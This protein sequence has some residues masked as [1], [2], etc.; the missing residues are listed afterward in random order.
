MPYKQ[1]SPEQVQI[2]LS[3][4]V[5][6]AYLGC[7][8]FLK[9]TAQTNLASGRLINPHNNDHTCHDIAR[10]NGMKDA[11]IGACDPVGLLAQYEQAGAEDE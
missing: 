5:T 3:D 4:P 1:V 9:E 8:E 10:A 2:W 6:V 7:L 11:F